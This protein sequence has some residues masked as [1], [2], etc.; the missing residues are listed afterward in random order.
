MSRSCQCELIFKEAAYFSRSNLFLCI[1]V[2]QIIQ[3]E[4]LRVLFWWE[5]AK[6]G[7][8]QEFQS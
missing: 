6:R 1:K 4:G 7:A 2:S 8:A 3:T 5:V